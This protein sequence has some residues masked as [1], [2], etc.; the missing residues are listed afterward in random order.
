MLGI[1]MVSITRDS[2]QHN[3]NISQYL[4]IGQEA[5]TSL[6]G[7]IAETQSLLLTVLCSSLKN[8]M[9]KTAFTNMLVDPEQIESMCLVDAASSFC[10]LQ[11]L[12]PSVSVKAQVMSIFFQPENELDNFFLL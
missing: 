8:I 6:A 2:Y 4:Q 7:T 3:L 1:S 12:N 9:M 5:F 10:K 11:H